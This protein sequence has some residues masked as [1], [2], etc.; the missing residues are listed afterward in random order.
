MKQLTNFV[1]SLSRHLD[2]IAGLCVIGTM[3]LVVAN[4]LL[5]TLFSKPILGSYEIVSYL[6]ALAIGF[7]LAHCAVQSGHI[8]VGIIVDRLSKS[9]QAVIDSA[10]NLTALVFWSLCVWHLVK[11]AQTT[12]KSGL[13]SPTAQ[14][15][16]APVIYLVALGVA[17]LCFIILVRGLDSLAHLRAGI[18]EVKF[19]WQPDALHKAKAIKSEVINPAERAIQ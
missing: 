13:V 1:T 11:F 3:L 8:A 10:I 9:L 12:A 18:L 14:I 7:A 15:P 6:T 4:I 5:R 19:P 16:V 2:K 17:S